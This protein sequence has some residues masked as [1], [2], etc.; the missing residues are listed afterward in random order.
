M[1]SE[2]ILFG[3]QNKAERYSDKR[4]EEVGEGVD[5]RELCGMNLRLM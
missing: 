2:I 1:I 5:Q 3:F 4:V